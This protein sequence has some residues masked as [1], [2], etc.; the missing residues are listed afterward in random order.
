MKWQT[1]GEVGLYIAHK[2]PID[3]VLLFASF[4]IAV[5][6]DE[7]NTTHHL[8]QTQMCFAAFRARRL[9]ICAGKNNHHLILIALSIN[10]LAAEHPHILRLS[11]LSRLS[12]LLVKT[13]P[14]Q[15]L[16]FRARLVPLLFDM[17]HLNKSIHFLQGTR[18]SITITTNAI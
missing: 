8:K 16:H 3:L 17:H 10:T 9:E 14:P 5:Y 13:I 1:G 7:S 12:V 4:G 15:P 11:F 18:I 6:I 2:I